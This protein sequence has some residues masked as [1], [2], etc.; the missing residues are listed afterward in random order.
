MAF[1]YVDTPEG[2]PAVKLSMGAG[3]AAKFPVVAAQDRTNG[4][5]DAGLVIIPFKEIVP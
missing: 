5:E 3:N 1:I 4:I 2:M